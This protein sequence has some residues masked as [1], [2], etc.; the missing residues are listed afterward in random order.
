MIVNIVNARAA[1]YDAMA[2]EASVSRL[3]GAIHYR[4]DCEKGLETG[5]KVGDFAIAR[6]LTDGAE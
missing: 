6:A 4:S 3:Y 5:K 1:D 2:K